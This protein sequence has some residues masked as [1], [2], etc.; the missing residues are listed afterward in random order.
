M[1]A[2]ATELDDHLAMRRAGA[3]LLSLALM[4]ARNHSLQIHT[5]LHSAWAGCARSG[6]SGPIAVDAALQRAVGCAHPDV[7]LGRLG[8]FQEAWIARNVQRRRGRACDPQAARL[9]SI[10]PDADALWDPR[11]ADASGRPALVLPG[12]EAVR[13]YLADTLEV[14]LELLQAHPQ[15][16]DSLY[17]FRLALFHEDEQAERLLDL[18]QALGLALPQLRWPGIQPR[19]CTLPLPGGSQRLGWREDEPGFTFEADRGHVVVPPHGGDIDATPVTWQQYLEFICDG[20]Y[21]D[22]QWWSEA[23]WR[24]REALQRRAPRQVLSA[25][26]AVIAQRGGRHLR[27]AAQ[28][29]VLQVSA[30]EAQAWCAWAGRRLPTEAE[31]EAAALGLNSRGW[32]WGECWEWT[33]DRLARR[34]VAAPERE[35]AEPAEGHPQHLGAA[36]GRHLVL[37]G[38]ALHSRRRMVHARR[39]WHAAPDSDHLMV[40]FR[41]CGL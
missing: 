41:S 3:D 20:G 8:W 12:N 36:W 27:V 30:H 29:P 14:T 16:D 19:A 24:W 1:L 2:T 37:R 34:P 26:G 17:F 33:I 32:R 31:W 6:R 39:R 7:W 13:Q 9:A 10:D 21:E 22:R 28:Q 11:Q 4:D 23:G 15:D 40:G 38:G 35:P 18:A 5:A 25:A